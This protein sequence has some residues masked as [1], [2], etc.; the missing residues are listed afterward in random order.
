MKALLI[1]LS[2]LA[3]GYLN[4]F[5]QVSERQ[6]HDS[7]FRY[8]I[9]QKQ[10]HPPYYPVFVKSIAYKSRSQA[11]KGLTSL[12]NEY[13]Q[14]GFEVKKQINRKNEKAAFL[15]AH[16]GLTM[17]V[18]LSIFEGHWQVAVFL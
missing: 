7:Y 2:L 11:E 5:A 1:I 12:L 3:N 18:R 8:S 9:I 10:R 15:L 13:T 4:L 17:C 14:E 16:D 6:L